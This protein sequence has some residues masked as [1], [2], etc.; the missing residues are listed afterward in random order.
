M[1][2]CDGFRKKKRLQQWK[3]V[4]IPVLTAIK[5]RIPYPPQSFFEEDIR[6]GSREAYQERRTGRGEKRN[7]PS[8]LWWCGPSHAAHNSSTRQF[9][10]EV[11]ELAKESERGRMRSITHTHHTQP[12][13]ASR[14]ITQHHAASR[15]TKQH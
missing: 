7:I 13:A 3:E 12:H 1:L 5:C 8:T 11:K 6:D 10:E 9:G 15:S 4:A 2:E 14:S